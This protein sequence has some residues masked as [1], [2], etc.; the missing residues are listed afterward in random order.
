MAMKTID[1]TLVFKNQ[2]FEIK[3]VNILLPKNESLPKAY[4]ENFCLLIPKSGSVS[5]SHFRQNINLFGG[6]ILMD[7]PDYDYTITAGN[8][9]FIVIN[10]STKFYEEIKEK[11]SLSSSYYFTKPDMF[12]HFKLEVLWSYYLTA[13]LQNKTTLGLENFAFNLLDAMLHDVSV[14]NEIFYEFNSYHYQIDMIQ[15]GKDF[16][17]LNFEED[18]SISDVA[19]QAH[20]SPFHFNRLFKKFTGLSPYKYIQQLRLI[21]AKYLLEKTNMSINEIAFKSGFSSLEY[22][23]TAFKKNQTFSPFQFRKRIIH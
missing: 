10:F 17:H 19:A 4:N 12:S 6:Y 14:S 9:A 11:H 16:I 2:D 15:A 3:S 21:H 1:S 23:C 20:M 18:I 5:F 8:G 13:L 7:K 22:F